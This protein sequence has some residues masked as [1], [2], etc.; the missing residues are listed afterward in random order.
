MI[1]SSFEY[2]APTSLNE[3]LS[4]LSAHKGEAKLL[5]GGH[6]L[7]PLM[8]F[9][10]AAPPYL[11]DLGRI[12]DL[13]YIRQEGDEIAIG[14]MT[15]HHTI[16]SS[17]LLNQ[18][19]PLLSE[20]AACI[21]DVQ[22]RNK[23]TIGGSLAH[24]DPAGDFPAA[25]LALSATIKAVG[26]GGERWIKAEDFFVDLLTTA[27]KEDE[28]LTEIRVPVSQSGT[29]TAY[30]KVPQKASGFAVCGVAAR[31]RVDKKQTCQDVAVAIT[32]IGPK[33]YRAGAVE[34]ALRGQQIDAAAVDAASKR[35]V[36][37]ID[38]SEDIHASAEY[39]AHLTQVYTRRAL[40][41]ALSRV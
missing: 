10:L 21:G 31:I 4:L 12:A 6:S 7:I 9:R 18:K 2:F 30:L 41:L 1:P 28:I 20:T 37:G 36:D 32:G 3:A 15:T 33:A 16:E 38:P 26:P 8:K 24:A 23:G 17:D 14:A 22:V 34:Q 40:M 29:G 5:A 35:A 27:L 11:I 39:R 19:C 13:A 25:V